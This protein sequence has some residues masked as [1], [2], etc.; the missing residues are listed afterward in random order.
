MRTECPNCAN[1]D[2][3]KFLR[4]FRKPSPWLHAVNAR[5]FE[6]CY[7]PR[8]RIEWVVEA[9]SRLDGTQSKAALRQEQ[10]SLQHSL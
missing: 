7:C 1:T 2:I 5:V 3:R 8:C 10:Y 4:I 9:P 6:E